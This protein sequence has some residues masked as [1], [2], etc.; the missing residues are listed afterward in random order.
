MSARMDDGS[1]DYDRVSQV[2]DSSRMAII[3]TVER[4]IQ[5]LQISSS[6]MVLDM[7][8][9]TGNYTAAIA[10][11][12][13][14]ILGTDKSVGMIRE[15]RL[16]YSEL[17]FIL[18]DVISLPFKTEIF[19]AAF[20]IQVI[21]HVKDKLRFLK[22]A[23]RILRKG[24]CF[25]IDLCSHQQMRTFWLYHYFP[26][27]LELDLARIPDSYEI[28][29]LLENAGFCNVRTEISYTDIV[30]E[31]EKPERYLDRSYRNG[32]STFHLLSDNDVKL[33]CKKLKEDINSGNVQNV[34]RCYEAKERR[35]GG[36][37]IIYGWKMAAI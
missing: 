8:C 32:Q 12:T 16:K 25:A 27:G 18:C 19:D 34:I 17:P 20:S 6:M 4:L 10:Q 26:K 24:A 31:H 3:E 36:S 23:H 37:S 7:G 1:I 15:A 9:G 33:G 21:H 2:Y 11:V 30:R 13:E 35:V 22:E 29:G 14:N 5:L 28:V